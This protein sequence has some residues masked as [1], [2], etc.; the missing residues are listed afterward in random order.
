MKQRPLPFPKPRAAPRPLPARKAALEL[1][2]DYGE[3]LD[4]PCDEPMPE[5]LRIEFIDG[6]EP[7]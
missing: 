2:E 5:W 1:P 4:K 7:L 3:G 6:K